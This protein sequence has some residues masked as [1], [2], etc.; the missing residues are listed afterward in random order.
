MVGVPHRRVDGLLQVHLRGSHHHEEVERPLVLLVGARRA[1]S[2]PG[3]AV[4]EGQRGAE[5]GAR[6]LARLQ[7][8][9]MARLEVEDLSARAQGKAEGRHRRRA[10]QPAPAGGAG[11]Q[12]ALPVGDVDV[13]GADR[14]IA[15]AGLGHG[16]RRDAPGNPRRAPIRA[17]RP[18]LQGRL[19]AQQAPPLIGVSAGQQLGQGHVGEARVAVPGLAVGE[20]QLGRLHDLVHELRARYVLQPQT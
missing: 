18:E 10:L 11:D 19:G 13:T 14:R 8:V 2:Q 20:G 9:G 3:L 15:D 1:E 7:R 4:A 12:V 5:C 6:P 17:S 16:R